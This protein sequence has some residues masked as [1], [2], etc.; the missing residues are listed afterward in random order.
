MCEMLCMRPEMTSNTIVTVIVI[1]GLRFGT[2]KETKL[3]N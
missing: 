2:Y 3:I 1:F